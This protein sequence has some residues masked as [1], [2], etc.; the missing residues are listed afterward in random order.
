MLRAAK[1]GCSSEIKFTGK[2]VYYD[3]DNGVSMS[4]LGA[5]LNKT[6]FLKTKVDECKLT[7]VEK[8]MEDWHLY[9]NGWY[10]FY[11]KGG[12]KN[13]YLFYYLCQIGDY[14]HYRPRELEY[15]N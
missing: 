13:K 9:E 10:V 4:F 3:W 7:A 8:L 1:N 12:F 14:G 5:K 15:F 2:K 11:P 6:A